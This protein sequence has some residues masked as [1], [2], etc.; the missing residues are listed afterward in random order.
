VTA[1]RPAPQNLA[2]EESVL[3]AIMLAGHDGPEPGAA[4]I[5]KIQ[6][7]GLAPDDFYYRDRHGLVYEAALAVAE[8]GEPPHALAV[9]HELRAR[10]KLTVVGGIAH[11]HEL[12]ALVPATANAASYARLVVEAAERREEVNVAFALRVA[13]ENG[14]LPADPDLRERLAR[15]G[16]R[17]SRVG[18]AVEFVTFEQ[19]V[20]RPELQAEPLVI[21]ADGGTV[22]AATGIAMVYG[23]GGA[24]K[25]TLWL[26]GAMHFAAGVEWLD[27]QV[28]PVRKLRVAWI[29]NEGPR[30][31]FRRKL[32]RKLA[33]WRSRVKRDRLRVLDR[34]WSR[35]D[36]RRD[37]HR[38]ALARV[39]RDAAVDL[40]V[41]GPL[42][43]LGMEG[44]GTPD[45]IRAFTELVEDVQRR[46]GRPVLFVIIHHENRAGQVSGAWEAVP[47]LLVH[48]QGQGHGRLR[49]FWQKARWSS[50]LHATALNLTWAEGEG[51]AVEERDELNDDAIAEQIVEAISADPGK[52][53]TRVVE[54]TPGMRDT[55]R[56]AVRDQLLRAGKIVNVVKD[57]SG[58]QVRLD[59]CPERRQAHLYLA[60][61]PTIGHLR[62]GRDADGTQS[63]AAG[64]EG[65][66]ADLRPASLPIGDAA[67]GP[68]SFTPLT[69][70][71]GDASPGNSG[72]AVPEP[73]PGQL[74]VDEVLAA[75][76]P[77]NA[78]QRGQTK[79]DG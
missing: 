42:H 41:V 43:R 74:T 33:L 16:Q 73:I 22:L 27:G 13:A 8:R 5:A 75:T 53:W 29:E 1:E 59:H 10:R 15:L 78:A 50:L 44:G 11:L 35:Y 61:D 52:G 25:T 28:R 6:A 54:R 55:R 31:E 30:E 4:V 19:F 79:E 48:V 60:G 49:V 12:A 17:R 64:G 37:D 36:L 70:L 26:D 58:Q 18:D 77:A 46:C 34:P 62:P 38:D 66:T 3:G 9:E 51:F 23:N 67:A 20:A 65:A 63:A 76:T 40:L 32:D 21:D 24:G 56:R 47:D 7:T 57:D 68:Q 45:E 69:S 71:G 39:V 72:E 2:A 14:G